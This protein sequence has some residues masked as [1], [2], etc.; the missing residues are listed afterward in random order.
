MNHNLESLPLLEGIG[1]SW[2]LDSLGVNTKNPGSCRVRAATESIVVYHL[3]AVL[4]GE[5]QELGMLQSFVS[6]NRKK[7]SG[8]LGSRG[9]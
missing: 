3:M 1:S 4:R 8:Q 9:M 5:L 2:G 6:Y 7:A